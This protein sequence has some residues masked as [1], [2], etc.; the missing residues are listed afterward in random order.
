MTSGALGASDTFEI[1]QTETG[2][3]YTLRITGELDIAS[4][5]RFTQAVVKLCSGGA[6]EIVVNLEDVWFI[7]SSGLHALLIVKERC[8]Q[9]RAV[10]GVVPSRYPGPRRLIEVAAVADRLPWRASPSLAEQ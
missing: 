8:A 4:A 10:Y 9:T 2:Q 1:R 5:S 6:L 7:D 3:R